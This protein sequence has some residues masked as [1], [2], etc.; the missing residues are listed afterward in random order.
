MSG[1]GIVDLLET[2]MLKAQNNENSHIKQMNSLFVD[3]SIFTHD[4]GADHWI[5]EWHRSHCGRARSLR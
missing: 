4:V 3:G 1:L 5:D 2:N